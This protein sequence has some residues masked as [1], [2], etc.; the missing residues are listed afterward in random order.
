MDTSVFN[1]SSRVGNLVKT[2]VRGY[3]SSMNRL[4]LK[5]LEKCSRVAHGDVERTVSQAE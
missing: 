4:A 3:P 1:I 5:A 2:S